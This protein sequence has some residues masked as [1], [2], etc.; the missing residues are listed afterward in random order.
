[1]KLR[2]TTLLTLCIISLALLFFASPRALSA[3]GG[4]TELQALREKNDALAKEIESLRRQLEE[5]KGGK[6]A[7]TTVAVEAVPTTFLRRQRRRVLATP[8][9]ASR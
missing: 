8:G 6:P 3:E 7:G 1:M 2:S 5:L 9:Q 4:E